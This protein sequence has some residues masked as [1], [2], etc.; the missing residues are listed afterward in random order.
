MIIEIL[1]T[2]YWMTFFV[3][4]FHYPLTTIGV[5]LIGTGV[6]GYFFRR[7]ASEDER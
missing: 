7:L 4:L 5:T 1:I 2:L 6:L 3:L